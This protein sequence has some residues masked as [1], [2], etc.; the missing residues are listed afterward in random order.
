VDPATGIQLLETQIQKA[1]E[2]LAARPLSS[3]KYSQW[4]LLTRNYL[5]KAFGR[6]SPNVSTVT[7]VGAWGA[8]PLDGGEA[9]WENHRVESLTTQVTHLEGLVELLRTESQLRRGGAISSPA[10]SAPQGHRV[11]LVHGH[12]ERWLQ[13]VARFLEQLDQEVIVLREQPNRGR[14]IIEKFEQYSE[15]GFAVVLLTA[16]DRGGPADEPYEKQGLRSRQNVILELGYFLGRL[17]RSRVCALY[18]EGVEIPSDYSGVLYLKLDSE[19][20]WRLHL[21]KELKAAGLPVDMNK[22]L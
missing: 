1:R 20:A 17:G 13:Q 21:A 9:W 15:V 3:D 4:E 10:V 14:T 11:F 8:F 5:E 18:V 19:G 7:N 12:A 2:L 16:D 6:N 22:A